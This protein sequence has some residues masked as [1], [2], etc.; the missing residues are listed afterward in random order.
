M[1]WHVIAFWRILSCPSMAQDSHLD[2]RLFRHHPVW[3]DLSWTSTIVCALD[4]CHAL[5]NKYIAAD[6]RM[7]Y[8]VMW[9]VLQSLSG[10]IVALFG[11]IK[12]NSN[13]STPIDTTAP[14]TADAIFKVDIVASSSSIIQVY[15]PIRAIVLGL[16]S[17][18][19]GLTGVMLVF[20][21]NGEPL[22]VDMCC[23]SHHRHVLVAIRSDCLHHDL[24]SLWAQHRTTYVEWGDLFPNQEHDYCGSHSFASWGVSDDDFFALLFSKHRKPDLCLLVWIS[25]MLSVAS[26]VFDIDINT[27]EG[28]CCNDREL[29]YG[30][31]ALNFDGVCYAFASDD[32]QMHRASSFVRRYTLTFCVIT[33]YQIHTARNNFTLFHRHNLTY[34]RE[35]CSSCNCALGSSGSTLYDPFKTFFIKVSSD[36]AQSSTSY[37]HLRQTRSELIKD[38][39]FLSDGQYIDLKHINCKKVL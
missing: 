37:E 3:G 34:R 15:T 13:C 26:D 17:L 14:S 19:R 25:I 33:P 11:C 21:K 12:Y 1:S 36:V 32:N 39:T 29:I 5:R 27:Y 6:C 30:I 8:R 9:H 4:Y 22:F 2:L 24:S 16:S 10:L 20:K 28:S 18:Q 23:F 31:L 7:L 38:I 35:L